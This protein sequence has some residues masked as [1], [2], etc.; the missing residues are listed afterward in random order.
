M[1]RAR[2]E[3]QAEQ[4]KSR[5]GGISSVRV[6]GR[7]SYR[8]VAKGAHREKRWTGSRGGKSRSGSGWWRLLRRRAVSSGVGVIRLRW[9]WLLSRKLHMNRP[10]R[11]K[12]CGPLWGV[13]YFKMSKGDISPRKV[14]RFL[15]FTLLVVSGRGGRKV[16]LLVHWP[17]R[18]YPHM[19]AFTT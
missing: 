6:P 4:K 8:G 16:W 17:G 14:F 2:A 13:K 18:T 12:I 10:G 19:S 5:S 3:I 11:R 7:G 1:G 9:R 15:V